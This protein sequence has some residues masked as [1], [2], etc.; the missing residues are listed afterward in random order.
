MGESG[1]TGLKV[2]IHRV[3]PGGV[4]S[5]VQIA[6]PSFTGTRGK[7]LL[8]KAKEHLDAGRWTEAIRDAQTPCELYTEQ[9]LRRALEGDSQ[10]TDVDAEVRDRHIK[11]WMLHPRNKNLRG[12][13]EDMTGDSAAGLPGWSDG[14]LTK[15]VLRRHDAT[16]NGVQFGERDARE[17]VALFEEL[18]AKLQADFSGR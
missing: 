3:D 7:P 6:G 16:H 18:V 4:F 1:P 10:V 2:T 15:C 17:I 14:R 12:L 9:L 5:E 8:K 11:S 13:Y